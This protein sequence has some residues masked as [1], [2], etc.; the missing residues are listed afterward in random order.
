MNNIIHKFSDYMKHLF[1]RYCN[2]EDTRHSFIITF[3]NSFSCAFTYQMSALLSEK[4]LLTK[5]LSYFSVHCLL[6][7][8]NEL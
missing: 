6:V 8:G 5:A 7:I 2:T 3:S 4:R 1:A